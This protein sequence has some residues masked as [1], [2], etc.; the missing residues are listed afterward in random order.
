[1]VA[2]GTHNLTV[3]E[4]VAHETKGHCFMLEDGGELDNTF[5]RNLGAS[6]RAATRLVR[7]FETDGSNPSTFWCSNPVNTYKAN[8]AAGSQSSGFWF[9][10]QREVRPPTSFMR[11][12]QG[13]VPRRLPLKLFVDNVAH[14]NGSHGLRKSTSYCWLRVKVLHSNSNARVLSFCPQARILLVLILQFK[15]FLT[16]HVH[17]RTNAPV[18]SFM[19]ALISS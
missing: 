11:T 17:I 12:S 3:S 16:I 1:M 14:S 6:T 7:A 4:T 10:L 13:L 2:H 8:V 9:E 5:V 18:S 15:Q 19:K